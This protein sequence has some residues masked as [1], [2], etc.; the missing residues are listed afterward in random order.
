MI[1]GTNSGI[2]YVS[3]V[4]SSKALDEGLVLKDQDS[5][6]YQT[7][8]VM[9]SHHPFGPSSPFP[10]LS[11]TYVQIS[12]KRKHSREQNPGSFYNFPSCDNGSSKI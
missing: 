4:A 3:S 11:L 1:I 2:F 9:P 5:G 7:L 10:V 12:T 8:T 6:P